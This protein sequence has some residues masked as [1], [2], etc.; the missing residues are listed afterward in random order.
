MTPPKV[1]YSLTDL[2]KSLLPA[3]GS[4]SEWAV[5]DRAAEEKA[6]RRFDKAGSK[7]TKAN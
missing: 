6:R 4:L 3:L 2:G 5:L 1:A 7:K